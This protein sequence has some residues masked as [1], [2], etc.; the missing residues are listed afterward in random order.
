M[1]ILFG[2]FLYMGVM[3]LVNDQCAARLLL[4]ATPKK[5]YPDEPY[6]Q[7]VSER[8]RFFTDISLTLE[9]VS[10]RAMHTFTLIQCSCLVL[11]YVVKHF[12]QSALAFPLIFLLSAIVR[13]QLLTRLF[14]PLELKAVCAASLLEGKFS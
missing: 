1:A 5:H 12:E 7:L 10:T 8:R 11:V 6:C 2:V 13:W 9:Q 14:S 3:M 4:L